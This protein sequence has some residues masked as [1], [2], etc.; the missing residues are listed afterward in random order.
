MQPIS[1]YLVT[2]ADEKTWELNR[3]IIFLGEW[4]RIYDRRQ[5]WSRLDAIVAK[6]YGLDND[7]RI[8]DYKLA[9]NL[10]RKYSRLYAI[11]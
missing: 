4:C 2:T 11:C 9:L 10:R 5:I 1:R 3:P 7:Q 6:P 8:N